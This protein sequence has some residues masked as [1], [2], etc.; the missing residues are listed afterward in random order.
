MREVKSAEAVRRLAEW[1]ERKKTLFID[2]SDAIWDFAETRYEEH[3]SAA[4]LGDVLEK[5][6][7]KVQ[8]AAGAIATAVVGG[9]GQ[10]G[11]IIAIL[12]EF[13]ALTG[14]SQHKGEAARAPIEEGGNGH[15][16]GH[17]LLGSGA[18]AAAVALRHYM[19]EADLPGT[20][21]YY[22]CPA[23]EGGGGKGL[24]VRQGLFD[25]VDAAVTWH[26][27]T[28]NFVMSY[29]SL[30]TCQ[31]YYRFQGRGAHAGGDAHLG[32]SALD[33]VEL[34]NVGCNY[35][36]E[37][38]IP[39]ARL[40]YAITNT[41]GMSPNVVQAEAEVLYKLRV[42]RSEQ[43]QD[44]YERVCNVAKG[45]ALMTGTE[46]SV[47]FDSGSSELIVNRVLEQLMYEKF[48]Q[49]GWPTFDDTEEHFAEQI[50]S[51]FTA[52][53]LKHNLPSELTDKVFADRIEPY[54]PTA[55]ILP[56]ST[57]VG[58]VSWNV[59]TVQCWIASMALGTPLHTWQAVSQGGTSIG[60]KGMLHAGKVIGATVLE[61]LLHPELLEQAKTEHRE[62]LKGRIYKCPFPDDV[63]PGPLKK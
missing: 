31:V 13:D 8:R 37:H 10:G 11:P 41:G 43:L 32:R 55:E 23:E 25:D 4:L 62:Q 38:L 26:P 7:F 16:C 51:T 53:E 21:R 30:A 61:L 5:E 9:Y 59:P 52:G 46:L 29:S 47:V 48:V 34:M 50:R 42:P 58:D 18:L 57:D 6:G 22:G 14:L 17:N 28:T 56:G 39:E 60:H 3:R 1:V 40:H 63:V 45:A 2:V 54:T 36:R 15:G 44:V 12:G 49:L 35:L 27:G 33:A 24:M 20:I 19:E